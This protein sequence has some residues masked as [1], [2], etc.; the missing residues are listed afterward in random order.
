PLC[1]QS[2]SWQDGEILY[3]LYLRFFS[4]NPPMIIKSCKIHQILIDSCCLRKGILL[5]LTRQDGKMATSEISPLPGYSEETFEEALKQLQMVTK[6]LLTTWWTKQ[7]LH[8]LENLG[9]SDSVYFGIESALL[10]LLEPPLEQL[11][12]KRYALLFGSHEEILQR[13]DEVYKEGF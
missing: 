3:P 6:R 10:E 4:W 11:S 8:Y 12:C 2:P 13:A 9:L 5:Q 1:L 7:A